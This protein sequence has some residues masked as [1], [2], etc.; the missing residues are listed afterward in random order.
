MSTLAEL[1]SRDPL[2]V[3]REEITEIMVVEFRKKR[4]QFNIGAQ[5]AGSTKK[6]SESAKAAVKAAGDIE[7]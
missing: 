4:A 3:T 2:K 1:F 7:I 5:Q 6:L